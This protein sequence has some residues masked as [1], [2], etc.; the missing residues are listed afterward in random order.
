MPSNNVSEATA[1]ASKLANERV[2]DVV[3][4]L[5]GLEPDLAAVV[6][7]KMPVA[8]A[9]HI[10]G[11]PGFDQPQK[12]I[13]RMPDETAV[14]ILGAMLADRRVDI[15]RRLPEPLRTRLC[16]RLAEPIRRSLLDLLSYPPSSAGGIMTTEFVS[17]SADWTASRTLEHIRSVGAGSET[18][19]AIYVVDPR[20]QQ[21][22]RALSLR[23]LI[24]GDPQSR[25][26]DIGPPRQP[27][28][29]SPLTDREEVARLISKYDLLAVPVVDA[30]GRAIGQG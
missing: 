12:L 21:L 18:I 2:A 4:V 16:A 8:G 20:T 10:L 28:T 13:E 26:A 7:E 5:N 22:S 15:F 17:A 3:E 14:A 11:Q 9:A 1:L 23:Q 19:Y 24:L 25:I 29:V 6:L 30:A 27:V